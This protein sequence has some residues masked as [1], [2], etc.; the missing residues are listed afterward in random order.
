MPRANDAVEAMLIEYADL[1][2]ILFEDP[3]KP[4]AYEK[5]ARAVGG[6]PVDLEG[7]DLPEILKVPSVGR[8]IGE[9]IQEFLTTGML[10]ELEELREQIPPGVRGLMSIPGLGPKKAMVLH[11]ELGVGI[12]GRARGRD[13][14]GPRRRAASV[15]GEDAGEHRPRDPADAGRRRAGQDRCRARGRGD[16]PRAPRRP[17]PRRDAPPTPA[18]SGG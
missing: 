5:A 3:Y 2:S 8:S 14:A 9:K 7:K 16:V 17:C 4:R 12:R 15:R 1:L 18:R 13:R 11:Q 6:Y 10:A